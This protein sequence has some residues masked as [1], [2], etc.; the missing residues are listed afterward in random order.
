MGAAYDVLGESQPS[1]RSPS[2]YAGMIASSTSARVAAERRPIWTSPTSS[3]LEVEADR[4]RAPE[5]EVD[6]H[7]LVV[8]LAGEQVVGAGVA[9]AGEPGEGVALESE[10]E[11]RAAAARSR[12]RRSVVE[13]RAQRV[14]PDLV[15][16]SIGT[17]STSTRPR[18]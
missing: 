4:G 3:G 8:A 7:Q 11:V 9:V 15:P 18:A 17:T 1:A 14:L 10:V 13:R 16:L 6:H 2:T 12:S 5:A